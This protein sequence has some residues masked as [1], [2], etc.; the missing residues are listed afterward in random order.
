MAFNILKQLLKNI[1]LSNIYDMAKSGISLR[2]R[3]PVSTLSKWS[4]SVTRT[5]HAIQ[6]IMRAPGRPNHT[7][8]R[9]CCSTQHHSSPNTATGST[10]LHRTWQAYS[11]FASIRK[12]PSTAGQ[13]HTNAREERILATQPTRTTTPSIP[14][15]DRAINWRPKTQRLVLLPWSQKLLIEPERW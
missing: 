10:L 1:I 11:V 3:K 13:R 5:F 8:E 9:L 15:V 4:Q 7:L 12:G 14:N 2:W 6:S